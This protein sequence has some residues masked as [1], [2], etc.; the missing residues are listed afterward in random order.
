MLHDFPKRLCADFNVRDER[1]VKLNKTNEACNVPN[2]LCYG[3]VLQQLMFRHRGAITIRKDIDSYKF[4]M[5]QEETTFL[6]TEG[7]A[8]SFANSQ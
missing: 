7:E 3:P 2:K 5:F 6:S 8:I 1:A 4:K